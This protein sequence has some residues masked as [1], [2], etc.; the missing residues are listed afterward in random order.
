MKLF[1]LLAAAVLVAA[2]VTVPGLSSNDV[3]D[4]DPEWSDEEWAEDEW[5]DDEGLVDDVNEGEL[6]FLAEPPIEGV[7]HHENVMTIDRTS[8]EDGWVRLEQCHRNIDNVPR[9]QIIFR[10]GRIRDLRIT[11]S[12]NIER[13]WVEGASVQLTD[14]RQGSRLCLTAETFTLSAS[15]DGSY[16]IKNGPFMR[17]FLDGYYPMRVSQKIIL[18]NSGLAFSG[19][20]PA[21]QPGF[22]VK[23][24]EESIDF[25]AWFEGRLLTEINLVPDD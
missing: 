6:Q 25:D 20:R 23:V 4:S 7:H 1:S 17:R 13:S 10:P 8:L 5:P 22:A 12:E 3:M 19:I 18:A 9:A 15:D 14:I 2:L 24:I 16:S 11:V 21:A